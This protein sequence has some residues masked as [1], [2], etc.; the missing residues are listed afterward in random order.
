[1][2]ADPIP[3]PKRD[4]EVTIGPDGKVK[5]RVQVND[6][7]VVKFKVSAYPSDPPGA[8]VCIVTIDQCN[9]T[10]EASPLRGQNT[11]KVGNG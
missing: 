11:I 6:G 8:N 2:A 3:L 4:T 7:D 9:I 5:G 1:M 10:W